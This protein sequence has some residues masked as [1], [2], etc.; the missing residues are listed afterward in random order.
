MPQTVLLRPELSPVVESES[1]LAAGIRRWSVRHHRLKLKKA[2]VCQSG[3][4]SW[5]SALF[6][7]S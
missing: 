1:V 5:C 2:R 3:L 4:V 7:L 6:Q